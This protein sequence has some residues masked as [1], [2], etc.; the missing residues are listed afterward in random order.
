MTDCATCFFLQ[1][2]HSQRCHDCLNTPYDGYDPDF[3]TAITNKIST[4]TH[5][6]MTMAESAFE[7]RSLKD[8]EIYMAKVKALDTISD[9]IKKWEEDH[10]Q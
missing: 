7:K 1:F 10:E 6:L 8:Y 9:F 2:G 5:W 4:L 3:K